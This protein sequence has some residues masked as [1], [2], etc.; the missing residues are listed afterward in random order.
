MAYAFKSLLHI[1]PQN[2]SFPSV[3]AHISR[4]LGER[5]AVLESKV[6]VDRRVVVF[7][8]F[9]DSAGK[10]FEMWVCVVLCE[11]ERVRK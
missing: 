11:G 5:V 10:G 1:A 7:K 6:L 3:Y 9:H 2:V 8:W 4:K